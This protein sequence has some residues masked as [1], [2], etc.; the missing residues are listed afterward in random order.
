VI[1]VGVLSGLVGLYIGEQLAALPD[2]ARC[3]VTAVTVLT[4]F[5][6]SLLSTS[7]T[8]RDA[9]EVMAALVKLRPGKKGKDA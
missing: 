4:V 5:G 2:F 6:L 3:V 1:S 9:Q 8:R 7:A